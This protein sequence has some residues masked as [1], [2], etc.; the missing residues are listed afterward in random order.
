MSTL[1]RKAPVEVVAGEALVFRGGIKGA[2]E[3]FFQRGS[4]GHRFIAHTS[5]K[6]VAKVGP[7]LIHRGRNRSRG[8]R[9]TKQRRLRGGDDRRP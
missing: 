4:P 1:K 9:G 2:P 6:R 8:D 5:K 7:L 3:T